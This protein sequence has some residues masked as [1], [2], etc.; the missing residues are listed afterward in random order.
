MRLILLVSFILLIFKPAHSQDILPGGVPGA[1]IWEIARNYDSNKNPYLKSMIDSSSL[2][3]KNL[4]FLNSKSLS[5]TKTYELDKF[6]V[7]SIFTVNQQS[8]TTEEQAIFSIENDTSTESVITNQRLA[9]L[10]A[11]L[12]ANFNSGKFKIPVI[13]SYSQNKATDSASISHRLLLGQTPHF[14]KLPISS[15][16]GKIPELILFNQYLSFKE[17]LQVESYLAIK[18]GITLNQEYPVNYLNSKGQIIWNS[19][20]NYSYNQNIAGIGKDELSGLNKNV[21]ESVQT[22]GILTIGW[23]NDITD[24]TFLIWGDNGG[25]MRFNENSTIPRR[26]NR[27]WKIN[28]FHA[29]S[30]SVYAET[31]SLAFTD[32]DP[33]KEGENLWMMIDRSGTGKYPFGKV[34]YI[35]SQQQ[36]ASKTYLFK[37]IDIDTDSSGYDVFTFIAAPKFF[38]RSIIIPPLKCTAGNTGSL[39]TEIVGGTAPFYIQLTKMNGAANK[40]KVNLYNRLNTVA[41]LEQGSYLIEITDAEGNLFTENI[42]IANDHIWQSPI[43]TGYSIQEG[44]LLALDA[45]SGMPA[46]NY[47]YT[48][49]TPD[50][51]K[52]NSE[53]ITISSA[54]KYLLSITDENGCSSTMEVQVRSTGNTNIKKIVLFPN[55]TTSGSFS[56]RISLYQAAS[57]LI[58]ISD[59][60]GKIVQETTLY[61]ND[62]YWYSDYLRQKGMYYI[63]LST[64][65]KKETIKLLVQ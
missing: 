27:E 24:N 33:L 65:D 60:S 28:T 13:Y 44:E 5:V 36:G 42:W 18:Y 38:G 3:N 8:D 30:K 41:N 29:S 35:L 56:L 37:K 6:P 10:D 22:P 64:H 17:Q 58:S 9:S 46:Q 2:T 52:L 25:N 59:N 48:W 14:Q 53:K 54:G 11:Y 12:Y 55:P 61:N 20:I 1:K 7:Y 4:I 34:D 23:L 49:E 40:Q 45:S 16:N 26:L 47:S 50:R 21:S 39:Q 15:F 51:K 57:V 62:Y 63:S 32:I 43:N 31:N 19:D